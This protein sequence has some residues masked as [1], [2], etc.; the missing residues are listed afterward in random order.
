MF[1]RVES[2]ARCRHQFRIVRHVFAIGKHL[3]DGDPDL[4]VT[5]MGAYFEML[6]DGANAV[7]DFFE[8][9]P[10]ASTLIGV[11]SLADECFL[12]EFDA[13]AAVPME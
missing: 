10:P 8:G 9:Q 5:N 11:T 2:L 4:F 1:R 12:M 7:P 6:G 3:L 13:I